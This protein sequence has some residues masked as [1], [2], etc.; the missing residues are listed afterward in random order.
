MGRSSGRQ[1]NI[2]TTFQ[3]LKILSNLQTTV[4]SQASQGW[5]G[6]RPSCVSLC[7]GMRRQTAGGGDSQASTLPI[8]LRGF[9]FSTWSPTHFVSMEEVRLTPSRHMEKLGQDSRPG[10]R[11]QTYNVLP[12]RAGRKPA[13]SGEEK[14][15]GTEACFSSEGRH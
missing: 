9:F 5:G 12:V 10:S 4:S 1:A 3:G 14:R 2:R 15:R 6:H 8:P 11:L 7:K 13:V